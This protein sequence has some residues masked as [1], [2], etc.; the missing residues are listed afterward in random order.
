MCIVSQHMHMCE[1]GLSNCFTVYLSG[2]PS[3]CQSFCPKCYG[4]CL[5]VICV[6]CIFGHYV[7]RQIAGCYPVH[8]CAAGV[9]QCL[10]ICVCVCVLQKKRKMLQAGSLRHLQASWSTKNNQYN[11]IRT[12][13]YLIQVQVVLYAVISATSYYR[14]FDSTSFE[15]A[16][17]SYS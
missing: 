16:H 11:H 6:T 10:R 2:C 7:H 17:D 3:G 15:I 13:L 8:P 4:I 9:K 5:V 14:F 12:F 1:T